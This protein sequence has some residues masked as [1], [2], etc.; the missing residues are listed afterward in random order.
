L[1]ENSQVT[2]R[3]YCMKLHGNRVQIEIKILQK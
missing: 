3:R 1:L 2:E